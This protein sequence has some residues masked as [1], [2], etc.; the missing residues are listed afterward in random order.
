M[1]V[2]HEIEQHLRETAEEVEWLETLPSI[3]ANAAAIILAEIETD[4]SRFPTAKHLASW[5][6]VCPGNK[7]SAGKR[8]KNGMT[9]GNPICARS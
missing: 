1:H 6:G 9:K 5:A 3:K 8:L 2:Q 4:I 7:E